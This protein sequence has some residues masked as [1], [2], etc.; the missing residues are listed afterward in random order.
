VDS[1][2][3]G[4]ILAN[5]SEGYTSVIDLDGNETFRIE[6]D[7]IHCSLVHEDK[8]LIGSQNKLYLVDPV[9]FK[10]QHSLTLQRQIYTMCAANRQTVICGEQGG[11]LAAISIK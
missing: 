5:N 8:L 10:V 11:Q 9:D 1:E 6:I 2:G 4:L 7:H 3:D